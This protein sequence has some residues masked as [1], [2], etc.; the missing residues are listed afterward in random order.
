MTVA[1]IRRPAGRVEEA[2]TSAAVSLAT[3]PEIVARAVRAAPNVAALRLDERLAL[4]AK[5]GRELARLGP[6]IVASA[7]EEIAQPRQFAEREFRTASQLVAAL[8]EFAAA[9]AT[10]SIM[11]ASGTTDLVWEPY[12]VVLGWHAANSPIWVPTVVLL[13]ALVAG[14]AVISRPSRR[15]RRTTRRVV[16][17]LAAPWPTDAV[18]LAD[19]TAEAAMPLLWDDSVNVIVT[20]G[21][22]ATCRRHLAALGEAYARGARL[23]PYIP[24][25]SGNDAL[26]VLDGADLDAAAEAV[27]IGGFANGGQL[28]MSAKRLIVER[29]V[30]PAFR[31]RLVDAVAGLVVGSAD[32][33]RTDVVPLT[34]GRAFEHA[35]IAYREALARGGTLVVGGADKGALLPT[36]VKLPRAALTVA[37]W[38]E[39][40][41]APVRGLVVVEGAEEAISV[42]NDSPYALGAAVFG[43]DEKLVERVRGARVLVDESPLYSDPHLVVGGVGDSG[44]AGARPKIE[45]LV[46]ARRV[47]RAGDV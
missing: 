31:P 19:M 6:E 4:A 46:W 18:V 15:A 13:S 20:H 47:H 10:R 34:A 8:P 7:I 3:P 11:A 37:L 24:E 29:S 41:F 38:A 39:E 28:C 33:P 14:N 36:I 21:S 5:S 30:W 26:L 40:S 23:R 45:Q 9:L 22:T 2:L 16:E 25:A 44:F 32:D 12:G 43:G 17:A 35:W 27:A 1:V 42:A